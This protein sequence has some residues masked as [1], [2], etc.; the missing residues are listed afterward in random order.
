MLLHT[1]TASRLSPLGHKFI[2][3]YSGFYCDTFLCYIMLEQ[4]QCVECVRQSLTPPVPAER[5]GEVVCVPDQ[6]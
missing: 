6:H 1:S 3:L 2:S 4:P 5:H